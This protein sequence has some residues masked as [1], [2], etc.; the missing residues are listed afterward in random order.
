V[1]AVEK[2]AELDMPVRLMVHA[3]ACDAV[4][5]AVLNWDGV[6]VRAVRP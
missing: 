2:P 1:I 6:H 4:L 3:R 5:R